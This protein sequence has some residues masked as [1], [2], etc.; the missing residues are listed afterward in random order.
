M[1]QLFRNP[2]VN[3]DI[4]FP[5]KFSFSLFRAREILGLIFYFASSLQKRSARYTDDSIRYLKGQIADHFTYRR[6]NVAS[7]S[8]AACQNPISISFIQLSFS[9]HGVRASG[10]AFTSANSNVRRVHLRITGSEIS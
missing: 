1:F 2:S 6:H 5:F 3:C 10:R 8:R 4:S 7:C 9:H